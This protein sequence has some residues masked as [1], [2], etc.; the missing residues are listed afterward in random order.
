[1]EGPGCRPPSVSTPLR[2]LHPW[3]DHQPRAGL[4]LGSCVARGS[5]GRPRPH[6]LP[7]TLTHPFT[8]AT[9]SDHSSDHRDPSVT[10]ADPD[11]GT[12]AAV[13]G[14]GRGDRAQGLT[15]SRHPSPGVASTPLCTGRWAQPGH[16]DPASLLGERVPWC[17]QGSR[18]PEQERS[19]PS[20]PPVVATRPARVHGALGIGAPRGSLIAKADHKEA[21]L[22]NA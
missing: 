17:Q 10:P 5:G 22:N 20:G 4:L 3:S 1:M 15:H 2:P 13:Q 6:R 11:T 7:A 9:K 18:P 8:F 19:C 21:L 14:G 12:T 16:G